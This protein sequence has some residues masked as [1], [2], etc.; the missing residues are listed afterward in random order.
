MYIIFPVSVFF[1]LLASAEAGWMVRRKLREHHVSE[2]SLASVRLLIGMLLTFSALVLGLLTTSAK[3]RFD[4]FNQEFSAFSVHLIEIDHSLKVYGAD[5]VPVRAM[6]RA[7]T[8]AA[9]ADTWPDE[10]M[11]TGRYPR[12]AHDPTHVG[13]ESPPLGELLSNV[14]VAIERLAPPDAFH[15][16]VAGR[17]RN[18]IAVAIQE[19][20]RLILLARSTVS[21]PFLFVL[22]TSLTIIFFIFTMITPRHAMLRTVVA[23]AALTIVSPL[24]LIID[25]S[26]ALDGLQQLSSTPMRVALA[27][28]D[29]PHSE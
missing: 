12:F 4:G 2:Q 16:Q 26:K 24:Y 9:I 18:K 20:W 17:L 15:Q 29:Q 22:A 11:P 3:Q 10:A 8:A 19:R 25:Y 27:H 28:M 21:R 7:Y 23:L 6:L 5:A 14:D 1:I 13:V